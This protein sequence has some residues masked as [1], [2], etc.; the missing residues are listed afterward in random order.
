MKEQAPAGRFSDPATVTSWLTSMCGRQLDAVTEAR[1][2]HEG[3]REPDARSLVHAWLFFAHAGP[4]GLYGHGDQLLLAEEEPYRSYDMDGHGQTRV[5]PARTPDVL[6]TF[7]GSRLSDGALI[8]GHDGDGICA[9]LLLRFDDGDLVIGTLGDE[10]VLS[11]GSVP[12]PAARH[13]A[14]QRFV[15]DRPPG[16]T[17]SR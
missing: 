8:L 3:R 11:V 5:G 17:L 15:G 14:V 1:Y 7:V 12:A 13:W 4:I 16:P 10:W 6:A 9:G 2:W